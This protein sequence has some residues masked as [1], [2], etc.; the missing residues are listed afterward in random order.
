MNRLFLL[1]FV[2]F[3]L[4]LSSCSTVLHSQKSVWEGCYQAG[5]MDVNGNFLSGTE[6]IYLVSHQGKLYAA[7]GFFGEVPENAQKTGAQILLK[8]SVED[9]WKLEYQFNPPFK[10]VEAFRSA[11]FTTDSQGKTLQKPVSILIATLSN[12][13]QILRETIVYTKEDSARK[14]TKNILQ[15]GRRAFPRTI[16]QYRDKVTG[17]DRVFIGCL[18]GIYTGVY[19]SNSPGAV[20]WNTIPEL[21]LYKSRVMAFAEC[22]APR[23]LIDDGKERM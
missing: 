14:W 12:Y 23:F 10:R 17:I 6:I 19:D 13:E 9:P 21:P 15:T 18:S 8:Q 7:N 5:Q 11:T 4:T 22:N 20:R 16:G 2:V 3:V 1:P